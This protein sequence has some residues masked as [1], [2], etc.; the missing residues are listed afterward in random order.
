MAVKRIRF[1]FQHLS[2]KLVPHILGLAGTKGKDTKKTRG[3]VLSSSGLSRNL[4]Q[5]WPGQVSAALISLVRTD[6]YSCVSFPI[7]RSNVLG[8]LPPQLGGSGC[9]GLKMRLAT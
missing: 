4:E 7:G 1:V 9:S 8:P 6:V 3:L 2:T 5:W